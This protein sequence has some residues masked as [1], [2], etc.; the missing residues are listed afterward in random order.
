MHWG[1]GL[2]F[3]LPLHEGMP[4]GVGSAGVALWK[5]MGR[6]E[7]CGHQGELVWS[8]YGSVFSHSDEKNPME[9][10]WYSASRIIAPA[11]VSST[12]LTPGR[13]IQAVPS[14]QKPVTE[15]LQRCTQ[16]SPHHY[17]SCICHMLWMGATLVWD[18]GGT[19]PLA[20]EVRPSQFLFLSCTILEVSWL[21]LNT[22]I[23]RC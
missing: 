1:S 20:A 6:S 7:S 5:S 17:R 18:R 4:F 14:W 2:C 3:C 16:L 22:E 23:N 13:P 10:Q 21:E 8:L 19:F 15:G 11:Q 9:C 12:C